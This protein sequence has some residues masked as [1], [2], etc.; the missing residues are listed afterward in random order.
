MGKKSKKD[1]DNAAALALLKQRLEAP[2]QAAAAPPAPPAA[3]PA[4]GAAAG[5][6]D[7]AAAAAAA[8]APAA[9]APPA[10]RA[11]PRVM[12]LTA[13][14]KEEVTVCG[15]EAACGDESTQWDEETEYLDSDNEDAI[16][17]DDAMLASCAP[18]R[19][20]AEQQVQ[21]FHRDLR[22]KGVLFKLTDAQ[23]GPK[24]T[25]V[26]TVAI[27]K[28]LPDGTVHRH[29]CLEFGGREFRELKWTLT[30]LGHCGASST[31]GLRPGMMLE[32]RVL[33]IAVGG[34]PDRVLWASFKETDKASRQ[35]ADVFQR[36]SRVDQEFIENFWEYTRGKIKEIRE[37][38]GKGAVQYVRA[39]AVVRYIYNTMRRIQAENPYLFSTLGANQS[40]SHIL[41]VL[42][43]W[44]MEKG[45]DSIGRHR[46]TPEESRAMNMARYDH[47][48]L[49]PK[50]AT[51]RLRKQ[52]RKQAESLANL[53]TDGG[54]LSAAQRRALDAK[55]WN[56]YVVVQKRSQAGVS[57]CEYRTQPAVCPGA[58]GQ[59]CTFNGQKKVRM[60]K[61]PLPVICDECRA[62]TRA[63]APAA[64]PVPAPAPPAAA[65]AA[66]PP[67]DYR[68]QSSAPTA[69]AAPAAAAA[70]S[71]VSPQ[72]R[73]RHP[74]G[75]WLTREEFAAEFGDA[76][77][78]QWCD[79]EMRWYSHQG[80]RLPYTRV[81][82]RA[83]YEAQGADWYK[84]WGE[85]TPLSPQELAQLA[86]A[87][88][89]GSPRAAAA[90]PH[91]S[92]AAA[93]P[94]APAAVAPQRTTRGVP[95][96]DFR[97]AEEVLDPY[98]VDRDTFQ[99]LEARRTIDAVLLDTKK[100]DKPLHDR[101]SGALITLQYWAKQ[102]VDP[103]GDPPHLRPKCPLP[104]N[105][106]GVDLGG[107]G[108]YL[109]PKKGKKKK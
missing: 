79:A 86:G 92:P 37:L 44:L 41:H 29:C 61:S 82:T 98:D 48:G 25:M 50:F 60:F 80:V 75:R 96:Q 57:D 103:E 93:P 52:L 55:G 102:P 27:Q 9:A 2:Q 15:D 56:K 26:F 28:V 20:A 105:A 13:E 91:P 39:N 23:G 63:W 73:R 45:I 5:H 10:G 36:D 59:G 18:A 54:A 107:L 99:T 21:T 65:P 6:R 88:T 51:T 76:H 84:L 46:I 97:D 85:M 100:S 22:G 90:P 66:A 71:V 24:G 83:Y 68:P 8:A 31:A 78:E 109:K 64:A 53:I 4:A 42:Y 108:A 95:L 67:P 58:D 19:R 3:A 1:K 32:I 89:F 69:P 7:P 30:T 62:A 81:E 72:P 12:R 74:D 106:A 47:G 104:A 35:P 14:P 17:C 70:A 38:E 87:T 33:C 43:E 77:K 11:A 40:S 49:D 16:W 101:I 34:G 94:P